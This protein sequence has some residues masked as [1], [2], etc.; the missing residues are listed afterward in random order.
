MTRGWDKVLNEAF[1][2][3][4][5][6]VGDEGSVGSGCWVKMKEWSMEVVG[7]GLVMD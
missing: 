7:L 5:I 1:G 6:G 4:W 3:G 2:S